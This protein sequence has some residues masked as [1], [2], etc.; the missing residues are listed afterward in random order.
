M[1]TAI[2]DLAS[3]PEHT[4]DA[5]LRLHLLSHRLIKLH[6]A[7]MTGIFGVLPNVAWISRST[8]RHLTQIQSHARASGTPIQVFGLG[9]IPP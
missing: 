5:Y 1:L 8:D 4:A 7:K 2:A 3:P 9:K 6:D